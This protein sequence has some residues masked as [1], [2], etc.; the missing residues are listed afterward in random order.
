MDEVARE[1]EHVGALHAHE[2]ARVGLLLPL[3]GVL[4]GRLHRVELLGGE[5]LR[6]RGLLGDDRVGHLGELDVLGVPVLVVRLEGERVVEHA[7]RDH[8]RAVVH[9]LGVVVGHVLA[10]L[11][12]EVLAHREEAHIGELRGEERDGRDDLVL[13]RVVVHGLDGDGVGRA[14]AVH[15]VLGAD[16]VGGHVGV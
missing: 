2:L 12:D 1:N 13:E 10:V 11:V 6:L 4:S 15:V 3:R 7:V 8:E 14:L 9:L 5:K 16:D